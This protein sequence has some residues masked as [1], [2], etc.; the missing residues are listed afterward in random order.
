LLSV[1]ELQAEVNLDK[2]RMT[3][4]DDDVKAS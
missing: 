1:N 3:N 2:G 4:D